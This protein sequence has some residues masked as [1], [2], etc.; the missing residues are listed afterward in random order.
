M[1]GP[2]IKRAVLVAALFFSLTAATGFQTVTPRASSAPQK[3]QGAGDKPPRIN[4]PPD[5]PISSD[6]PL[7]N[8]SSP[9]K[10]PIGWEP[11]MGDWLLTGSSLILAIVSVAAAWRVRRGIVKTEAE[12]KIKLEELEKKADVEPEK[13]K[14][15][16]ELAR[17]TLESYFKRNLSHVRAIFYVS[18]IAMIA[19]FGVV[20]WGIRISIVSPNGV[21]ISLIASASGILTEFISLTF[22]AIYRSTLAQANEYV[23]V[24]ERI[25]TVGMAVQ[26]LDSMD[27]RAEELK[28]LTR[29]EIVR[30]LLSR[31]SSSPQ[32]DSTKRI[33]GKTT[34][35]RA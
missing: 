14:P 2:Q 29:A 25:N 13:L 23:S 4:S 33:S 17:F 34:E 3:A 19:G 11:G 21:K 8:Q 10:P 1:A 32:P 30:L 9:D 6:D 31:A 22:M 16:W 24:L 15:V 18:I 20:L 35:T 12:G 28:D 5:Q 26:I 7:P 27:D